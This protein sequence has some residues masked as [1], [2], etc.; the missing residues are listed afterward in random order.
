M[1]WSADPRFRK[2]PFLAIVF[3]SIFARQVAPSQSQQTHPGDAPPSASATVASAPATAKFEVA[4]VHPSPPQRDLASSPGVIYGD[5]YIAREVPMTELISAAYGIDSDNVQGGPNWVEFDRFDVV[6]KVPPA[7]SKANL[8]LMLQS[9]LAER[10][11]LKVHTGTRPL[12]A[13]MLTAVAGDSKL[14][15]SD[16]KGDAAC[17]WPPP[18]ANQTPVFDWQNHMN[19]HNETMAKF[20]SDIRDWG[21][22]YVTKAVV[23]NTGL[24]G[25]YDF[26]LTWTNR[27]MMVRAGSDA[28]S[29]FDAVTKELGLK[30]TMGTAPQPVTMIDSV[31]ESPAPNAADLNQRLPPLPPAQFEVAVITPFKPGEQLAH[32]NGSNRVSFEGITLKDLIDFA[33]D[34]DSSDPE[35]I[36]GKPKWLDEDRFDIV[37]QMSTDDTGGGAPSPQG[38]PQDVLRQMLRGLI[39]D[40]FQLKDHTED[41]PIDVYHLVA[42]NPK[43]AAGDPNRR[44]TCGNGPGPD[45]KD[46]RLTIPS[47]NRLVTCQNITM[48][49]FAVLVRVFAGG[50]IHDAVYDDTGIKGTYSFTLSFSGIN[51]IPGGALSGDSQQSSDPNGA[52]SLFEAIKTELGLKLEKEKHPAPVLVIDHIEEKPSPN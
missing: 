46:P 33:W 1:T 45:G 26:E 6:A 12:P 7:T 52:I 29:L 5:R 3:L 15:K 21:T 28:I 25:A 41:H 14:K 4:D 32:A 17:V 10:F 19:C 44:A 47:R 22:G 40:R 23:D 18:P 43:M 16:G 35:A 8:Q 9:L 11:G 34:L 49:Q 38:I 37:A 2:Y 51:L 27:N 42:A 50:Y 30:L 24:T 36:A 13:F 31:N 20:A 48:G 39:E